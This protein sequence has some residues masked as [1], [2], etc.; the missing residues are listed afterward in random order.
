VTGGTGFLGR[1]VVAR[2]RASGWRVRVLARRPADGAMDQVPGSLEDEDALTGLVAGVRLVV[3]VAGLTR[4]R[5]AREFHAVNVEGAKRLGRAIRRA[6][7]DARIVAVSSLAAREPLLS[8]YAASKAAGEGALLDNAASAN[9]MVLRPSALYGPGDSATL[10]VFRAA[11]LP[12]VP[13]PRQ[14]AARMALLHV[15][16]AAGAVIAAAQAGVTGQVWEVGD[17][18]FAWEA[19]ARAAGKALGREVALVPVPEPV[20]AA[21]LGLARLLAGG[22]S[23]LASPGKLAELLHGDWT[24]SSELLPPTHLWGPTIGLSDGFAATVSWYRLHGWL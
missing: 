2:L 7:P 21:M 13:I 4:A 11:K 6:A 3:H 10:P 23:P 9:W 15:A 5:F 20:L 12:L 24:C 22:G 16:D 14:P 17:G 19:I 1:A 8:P 18:C